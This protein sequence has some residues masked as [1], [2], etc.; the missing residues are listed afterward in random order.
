MVPIGPVFDNPCVFEQKDFSHAE[1]YTQNA[2]D[3]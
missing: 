1:G 3:P 2:S